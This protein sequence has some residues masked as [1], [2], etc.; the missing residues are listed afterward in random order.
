MCRWPACIRSRRRLWTRS[1]STSSPGTYLSA[2]R[3]RRTATA[4]KCRPT[5]RCKMSVDKNSG[6][7]DGLDVWVL[8]DF[9]NE[10]STVSR[11]SDPSHEQWAL[12]LNDIW[13][14]FACKVK[15]DVLLDQ[16]RRRCSPTS[17]SSPV[18]GS[19]SC[20]TGIRTGSSTGRCCAMLV[21]MA[22]N[23]YHTVTDDF[24]IHPKSHARKCLPARVF[25]KRFL[26]STQT[27]VHYRQRYQGLPGRLSGW[28]SVGF[29]VFRWIPPLIW[30][31]LLSFFFFV[32]VVKY[33]GLME[34]FY[35]S[36]IKYDCIVSGESRIKK[37][38]V[39]D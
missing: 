15:D 35:H 7:G 31:D 26:L 37:N 11:N 39:I 13:K 20:V 5:R 8:R 4:A 16:N 38:P 17:R 19:R 12:E 24:E 30:M 29:V 34:L 23:Y 28:C 2:G 27:A 1:S 36:V 3:C 18:T 10:P 25:R 32:V 9:T 21:L 14:D 33:F 6:N 22:L